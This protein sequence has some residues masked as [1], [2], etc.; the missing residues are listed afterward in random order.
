MAD[1]GLLKI[2]AASGTFVADD[3]H[4]LMALEIE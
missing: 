3:G 4:V 1:Y 2:T